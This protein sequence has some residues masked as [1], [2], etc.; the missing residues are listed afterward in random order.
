MKYTQTLLMTAF[1]AVSLV[2][3]GCVS[4][5]KQEAPV[6]PPVA[7][8]PPANAK[9]AARDVKMTGCEPKA[10]TVSEPA[11]NTAVTFPFT[12]KAVVHNAERKDCSWTMFEAQAASME[13]KDSDGKVVASGLLMA[14]GEW[15]TD[16]PVSFDGMITPVSGVTPS[17]VLDLVITEENPSGMKDSQTITIPIFV[18]ADNI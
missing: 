4:I 5:S 8:Q 3:G 12:V 2:G 14:K 17:G 13:V 7:E 16:G 6:I 15:M 18:Q 10:I 9:V 11:A 1:V